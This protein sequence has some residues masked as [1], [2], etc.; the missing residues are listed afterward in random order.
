MHVLKKKIHARHINRV[1]LNLVST[2][3]AD[4]ILAA[5]EAALNHTLPGKSKVIYPKVI[6]IFV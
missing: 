4:D 6:V 3:L 5:I 2:T 1:A